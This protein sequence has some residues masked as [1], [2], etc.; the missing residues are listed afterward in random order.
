MG[1][2]GWDHGDDDLW[3]WIEVEL[4]TGDQKTLYWDIDH[5]MRTHPRI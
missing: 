3:R 4:V 1:S 2:M 5:G